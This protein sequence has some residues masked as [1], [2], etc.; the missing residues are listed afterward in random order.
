VI[1]NKGGSA[2]FL[3]SQITERKLGDYHWKV[4]DFEHDEESVVFDFQE[5]KY[6]SLG[7]HRLAGKEQR[8]FGIIGSFRVTPKFQ[9]LAEKEHKN[10]TQR[11]IGYWKF[12]GDDD[13]TEGEFIVLTDDDNIVA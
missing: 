4:Y 9:E 6:D 3:A 11:G 2:A 13:N 10:P 5:A 8:R 12:D 1:N 7:I